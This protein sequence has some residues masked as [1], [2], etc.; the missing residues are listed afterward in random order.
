MRGK[1]LQC[2]LCPPALAKKICDMNA[3]VR[4]VSGLANLLV[5]TSLSAEKCKYKS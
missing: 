3:D 4:S 1:F 5:N 2:Q